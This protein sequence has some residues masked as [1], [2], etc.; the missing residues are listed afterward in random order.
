LRAG[1]ER[2]SAYRGFVDDLRLVLDEL[3][4]APPTPSRQTRG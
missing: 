1:A 2:E 4:G 3:A